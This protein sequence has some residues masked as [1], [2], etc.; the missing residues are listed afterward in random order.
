MPASPG[1]SHGSPLLEQAD[2]E[3]SRQIQELREQRD[4]AKARAVFAAKLMVTEDDKPH[5]LEKEDAG[6]AAQAAEGAKGE[7]AAV[8]E[9]V[10]RQR[11]AY[12]NLKNKT[13]RQ[14]SKLAGGCGMQTKR[15]ESGYRKRL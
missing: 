15:L 8:E 1:S 5:L 11:I 12:G 4:L 6:P 9:H 7:L 14:T 13:L 10:I 3:L 2:Y